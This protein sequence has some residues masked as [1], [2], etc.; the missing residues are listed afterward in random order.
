MKTG[1]TFLQSQVFSNLPDFHYLRNENSLNS[2]LEMGHKHERFL[3]SNEGISG[4]P[5]TYRT[6]LR[7]FDQFTI[8]VDR[9]KSTHPNSKI[10]CCFREP[11]SFIQSAYKQYLHVGGIFEFERFYNKNG[12]GLVHPDDFLF[13]RFINYLQANFEEKDLFIYNFDAFIKDMPGVI[14]DILA[15]IGSNTTY[16]Q[17]NINP[18]R[19]SNPSVP[20]H[21]ETTLIKANKLSHWYRQKTGKHLQIKLFGKV[22]NGR[23]IV[24]YILPKVLKSSKK[25]DLKDLK[26]FYAQDWAFC[27]KKMNR[28]PTLTL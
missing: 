14:G 19:K 20:D 13:S 1:T 15:F 7:Y 9:I 25:R 23:V 24:Q 3:I 16:D 12:Q 17:L 5:F 28:I 2:R 18:K 8:A 10:I 4:N 26:Q 21:L 22:I 11:S 27:L 6:E